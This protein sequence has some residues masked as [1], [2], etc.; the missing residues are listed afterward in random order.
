MWESFDVLIKE[1]QAKIYMDNLCF[2][3]AIVLSGSHFHKI[4]MLSDI[5]GL[6]MPCSSTF[7]A[8]Q[9]HYV[10]P[11]ISTFYLKN[12]HAYLYYV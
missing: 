4:K 1:R 8:H 11:G 3:A 7:H 9:R 10:C 12:I 6:H 2:S 5:F